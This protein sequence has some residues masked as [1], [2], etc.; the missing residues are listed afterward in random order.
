[1]PSSLKP[2]NIFLCVCVLSCFSHVLLFVSLWTIS[3]QAPLSR[4]EYW[5]GLQCLPSKDLP[6][7]GI[8]PMTLTSPLSGGFFTTSATWE[9]KMPAV[10]PIG[11]QV[12][13]LW[14]TRPSP[15]DEYP[16]GAEETNVN[17]VMQ[18]FSLSSTPQSTCLEL[19]E[20][21]IVNSCQCNS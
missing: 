2:G 14:I 20:L 6:D 4:Q 13:Y 15:Q 21:N 5:S 19:L 10:S 16:K 3:H 18:W 1:M 17:T 8:E 7:P 11:L 12:S 9:G